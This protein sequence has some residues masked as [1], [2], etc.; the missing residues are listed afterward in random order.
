MFI[1]PANIKTF[2]Q[3]LPP[4][5]T[6][7]VVGVSGGA[8]S[9]Y[10]CY[11]LNQ[12][13]KQT[14]KELI[15]VTVDHA[16]RPE[17]HKEAEWVHQQLSKHHIQH[18]ILLWEGTKPKTHIEEYA[19]E[20]RY[21]LLLNF[22]HQ[23][24]ASILFL[25]HHQK[26]Q[27]ETFWIRL[28]RGSGLDGLCAMAPITK[29][30]NILIARP[31]LTTTKED[32][33]Q[34]LKKNRLKWIE[35]PMNQSDEFERVR[36]RKA[37]KELDKM[38]LVSAAI[39]KSTQRLQRAKEALDFYTHDFLQKHLQKSPYGFIQIDEKSFL[40][41]PQDVRIRVA[42]NVLK[43]LTPKQTPISLESVEKIVLNMPKHATLAGCLWV[44]SHHQIFITLELKQFSKVPIPEYKWTKWGS[45]SLWT[46]KAF[47]A[48]PSAPKPRL[49][50]I[51]YLIQRTFLNPPKDYQL[52]HIDK[53]QYKNQKELEKKLKLDYK[54]KAFV[55]MIQFNESKEN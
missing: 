32:I 22:C 36:W 29:R 33:L 55:I 15:A 40:L 16:L 53:T 28:S 11:I 52:V 2:L 39:S 41:L 8:D 19:R 43:M 49:K 3:T 48:E 10:L 34:T 30:Q 7:F 45:C 44:I 4:L 17:S 37:Q 42:M 51:P 1:I 13:A 50:A 14:Q 24:Q 25:A 5:K 31:L 23:K 18:E 9:L 26:D 12:W 21:E 35:D 46:N 27:A 20:K 38:G 6:P 54:N 47:V